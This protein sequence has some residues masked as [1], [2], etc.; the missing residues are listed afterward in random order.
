MIEFT[1]DQS[2]VIP[3]RGLVYVLKAPHE[4]TQVMQDE[5]FTVGVMLNGEHVRVTGVETRRPGRP[6]GV[7][8]YKDEDFGLMVKPIIAQPRTL[9]EG[10]LAPAEPAREVGQS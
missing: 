5:M 7:V 9:P 10:R 2:Y 8:V 1:A 6:P 3:G 4:I